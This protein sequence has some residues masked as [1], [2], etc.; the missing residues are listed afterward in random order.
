MELLT[1]IFCRGEFRSSAKLKAAVGIDKSR[2][3]DGCVLGKALHISDEAAY[4]ILRQLGVVIEDETVTAVC[5]SERQIVVL[6]ESSDFV[7][8]DKPDPREIGFCL[9]KLLLVEEIG[10]DEGFDFESGGTVT[11]QTLK[12]RIKIVRPVHAYYYN[13]D[14]GHVGVIP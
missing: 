5:L 9:S 7:A 3:Y 4:D 12:A 11:T 8:L 1:D 2:T 14:V 6:C 10:H 13:A